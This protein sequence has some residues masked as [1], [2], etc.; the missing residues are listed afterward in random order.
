MSLFQAQVT[1][2]R[3]PEPGLTVCGPTCLKSYGLPG[4]VFT[5]VNTSTPLSTWDAN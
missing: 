4:T 5:G 2:D 3:L 1:G